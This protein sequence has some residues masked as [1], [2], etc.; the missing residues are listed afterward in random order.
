MVFHIFTI[1]PEVFNE[2]FDT[3]ILGRAQKKKLVKIKIYDIRKF[4]KDKH[5]TTDDRPFG[6]GAGMVMKAEPIISAI[7]SVARKLKDKKYKIIILSAKGKQ[8]NQKD[9]QSFSEKYKNI[10]LICGR[11]EGID[12]RVKIALQAQEISI[13]PYVLTDGEIAAMAIISGISR[14]VPGVVRL[15]SLKEESHWNLIT[16]KEKMGK[17]EY[18][19]YT[20]P[21]LF[22]YKG[23]KFRVPKVLLSGNHKKIKQWREKHSKLLN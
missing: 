3:S 18:P 9:A 15:E 19:H 13:G 21:E 22:E 17:L 8:F 11:Y 23:K 1:F 10:F 14:L 7:D 4:A 6:G 16:E 12:E 2:Y 5:K 20:R